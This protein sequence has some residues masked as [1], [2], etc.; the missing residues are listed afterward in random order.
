[1]KKPSLFR[2]EEQPKLVVRGGV[3]RG[4]GGRGGH[5]LRIK[6]KDSGVLISPGDQPV[7]FY[8]DGSR[9]KPRICR[10]ALAVRHVPRV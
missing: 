1:M 3:T 6:Y 10:E 4:A 5:S 8:E 2:K 9:E 7:G